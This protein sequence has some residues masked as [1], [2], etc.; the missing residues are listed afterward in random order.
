MH[1]LWSRPICC[2][3]LAICLVVLVLVCV[4]GAPAKADDDNPF[5]VPAAYSPPTCAVNGTE[6]EARIRAIKDAIL[7]KLHL[8][9]EPRNPS[10]PVRINKSTRSAYEAAEQT[11]RYRAERRPQECRRD[12]FFAKLINVFVPSSYLP[13]IPPAEVFDWG[14]IDQA[15]VLDSILIPHL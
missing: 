9:E 6:A 4:A 10:A 13:V 2:K 12:T 14:E 5:D 15:T 8:S 7:A 3:M 1:A 11:A